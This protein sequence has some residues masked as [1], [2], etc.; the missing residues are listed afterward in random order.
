[1]KVNESYDI[2]QY[3]LRKITYFGS[4]SFN[5]DALLA[6]CTVTNEIFLF[7]VILF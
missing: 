4:V 7:A 5:C 3:F 6:F 2:P 1:M